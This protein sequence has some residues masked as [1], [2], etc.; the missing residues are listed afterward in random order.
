MTVLELPSW[1]LPEGGQF[2]LH[3]SKALQEAGC[4]V[5]IL[6]NVM[7]GWKKYRT[8]MFNFSRFPLSPFFTREEG[9]ELLRNYYRPYPRLIGPN[10][11][12]WA[13]TTVRL[14]EKYADRYGQPDIIH[15]HSATWGAYAASLIKKKYGVPY[16]V[17]EHRGVFGCKCNYARDFFRPEFADFIAQGYSNADCLVPVSD[18][19]IPKMNEFLIRDV[20][21]QV[22]S[23]IVNTDFFVPSTRQKPHSP[24]R[25]ISVNGY[26]EVKGYDIMLP[27]FDLLCQSGVDARLRLV[28][29]N[30][31]QQQFQKLLAKTANKDK[32]SFAGELPPDGVKK[33]LQQADAFV[34]SSRVEAEPVSILEALSCGLP[35]AGTDVIPE[36]ELPSQFGIRVPVEQ[37]EQLAKAMQ[38]VVEHY[39]DYDANAAHRHA[40]TIANK[41]V[42]AKQ[43]IDIFES[44]CANHK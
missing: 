8:Q 40:E 20:Q 5:R 26:Y 33:E 44:V 39:A 21:F 12:Q 38:M 32:I 37:P 10:I 29:E 17:T 41:Q 6:A 7:L 15:V 28:G 16:V 13:E 22:V 27:A 30:F 43:L 36:Y 11:R 35:V 14:Y 18:Q 42:V 34:M 19:L 25:F 31:G 1:Y 3:Q 9:V 23:N 24:F 4:T 2:V